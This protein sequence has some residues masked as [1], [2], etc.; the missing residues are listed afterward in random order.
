MGAQSTSV[1]LTDNKQPESISRG[2]HVAGD[3]AIADRGLARAKSLLELSA[4]NVWWIVRAHLGNLKMWDAQGRRLDQLDDELCAAADAA[5]G[6]VEW[7]VFLRHEGRVQAARLIVL[8]LPPERAEAARHKL[9]RR[10][11]R[12]RSKPPHE[13]TLRLAGYVM[14]LTTLPSLSRN[15]WETETQ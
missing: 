13:R 1:Q 15:S 14:L 11:Q 6:P 8:A 4:R 2:P 10:S 9:T 5:K 12:K 7:E 3:L